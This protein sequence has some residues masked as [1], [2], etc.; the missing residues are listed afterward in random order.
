MVTPPHLVKMK[1]LWQAALLAGAALSGALLSQY[2]LALRPCDLCLLQRYPYAV[3]LL[4]GLLGVWWGRRGKELSNALRWVILAL[5]LVDGGIALYHVGVE[6]GWV[7]GPTTCSGGGTAPSLE[8]LRA[9]IMG[10]A[11]VSC[12]DAGFSL[13]GLSMAA[14]NALY[15]LLSLGY[16]LYIGRRDQP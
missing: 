2:A 15:A 12:K 16:L 8:A 5:F 14:W 10:A 13:L 9:E 4:L 11:L 3:I 7:T 6:Q 1:I